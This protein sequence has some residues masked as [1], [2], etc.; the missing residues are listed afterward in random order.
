MAL[1]GSRTLQRNTKEILD[2]IERDGEPVVILRHGQPVAALIPVDQEHAEALV[3][4]TSPEFSERPRVRESSDEQVDDA[5]ATAAPGLAEERQVA[6]QSEAILLAR[7]GETVGL[8]GK[9]TADLRASALK[10]F[11]AV[12]DDLAHGRL[13]TGPPVEQ[14][15]SVSSLITALEHS[16]LV[17]AKANVLAGATEFP[18]KTAV[19]AIVQRQRDSLHALARVLDIFM[20][21]NIAVNALLAHHGDLNELNVKDVGHIATEAV[22]LDLD[23]EGTD[24]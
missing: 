23:L 15:E 11:L 16:L 21:Q 19:A 24:A 22:M 13:G 2:D 7:P 5:S 3:L 10:D 6:A 17:S 4:A 8:R 12:R 9:M 1:I 20:A 18:T 14:S